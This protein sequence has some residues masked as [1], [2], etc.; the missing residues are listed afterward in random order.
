MYVNVVVE[1][2]IGVGELFD[3][4][5]VVVQW[6]SYFVVDMLCYVSGREVLNVFVYFWVF[7]LCVNFDVVRLCIGIDSCVGEDMFN[8]NL[9]GNNRLIELYGKYVVMGFVFQIDFVSGVLFVVIF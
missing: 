2:G 7:D 1:F 9:L 6:G 8:N 5:Y 4:D 3:V